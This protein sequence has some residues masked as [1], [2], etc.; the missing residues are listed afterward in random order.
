MVIKELEQSKHSTDE[1]EIV[2]SL[3]PAFG[4]ELTKSIV[5]IPLD[6]VLR[7]ICAGIEEEGMNWR[8]IKVYE[9]TDLAIIASRGSKLSGSGISV[10][11]QSRGTTVIHQRDLVPLDNLELF[12]QSP[13][14]T[15]EIFR[16]I[17]KNA[18]KYGRGENPEPVDVINDYMAPSKYL[19]KS[20]L[21]HF[22]ECEEMDKS[23]R[24]V[25]LEIQFEDER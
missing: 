20:T 24:P 9:S 15:L 18:A 3:S 6:D 14:Y 13:L 1:K 7:E 21:M 22:V 16:K 23:R 12:P 25:D 8:F 10:G 19:I 4:T 2:I 17:G 5:D 11:L